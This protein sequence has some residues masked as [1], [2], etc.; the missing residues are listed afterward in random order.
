M[1]Q[2]SA[3]HRD[4]LERIED[5]LDAKIG[6]RFRGA[7]EPGAPSDATLLR[8]RRD[9]DG[10]EPQTRAAAEAWLDDHPAERDAFEA[11]RS[12]A[13]LGPKREATRTEGPP[14]LERFSSWAASLAQAP[15]LSA[16]AVV[17]V[18]S[19]AFLLPLVDGADDG[20]LRI[21]GDEASPAVLSLAPD[22]SQ[23]LVRAELPAEGE[24]T[25]RLELPRGALFRAPVVRLLRQGPAAAPPEAL[26]VVKVDATSVVIAVESRALRPGDQR[27]LLRRNAEAPVA[28]EYP[29]GVE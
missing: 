23:R 18:V 20:S 24:V 14:W 15:A 10:L 29:F 1:S 27:I 4:R 28:A 2:N 26:R 8:L 5:A 6:A 13:V 16:L 22:T 11:F 19:A 21:R 17:L 12:L 9:P 25:I 3:T 7:A